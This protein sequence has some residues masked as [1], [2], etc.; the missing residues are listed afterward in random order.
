M[1]SKTCTGCGERKGVDCF[2]VEKSGLRKMQSRC[3]AC[4]SKYAVAV[5]WS[6]PERARAEK[7]ASY[8]RNP[9]VN[10]EKSRLKSLGQQRDN[11]QKRNAQRLKW[12][13]AN[14]EADRESK[15]KWELANRESIRARKKKRYYASKEYRE[16]NKTWTIEYRRRSA[17]ADGGHSKTDIALIFASQ[18]GKCAYCAGIISIGYHV[19]HIVPLS[20]GG[21][22]WPKNIQLLCPT[23]NKKKFDKTHEEYMSYIGR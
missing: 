10:R 12:R 3:K 2:S 21:S 6:N 8:W 1:D 20:R 9:E 5:Y 17:A 15:R 23:C 7:S 13:A 16:Q 4:R 18:D 11:P 14:P 19:D 22:N